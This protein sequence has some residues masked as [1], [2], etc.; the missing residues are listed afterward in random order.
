MQ[1]FGLATR[2]SWCIWVFFSILTSLLL[3]SKRTC[4]ILQGQNRQTSPRIAK[5]A[6]FET[7]RVQGFPLVN[8]FIGI[9]NSKIFLR[10]FL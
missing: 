4:L 1:V 8:S 6:A 3:R 10:N 2:V 5:L 9:F 7:L